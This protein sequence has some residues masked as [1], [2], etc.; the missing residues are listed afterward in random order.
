MDEALLERLERST[1][2]STSALTHSRLKHFAAMAHTSE[3][4]ISRVGLG[5]SIAHGPIADGFNGP[6]QQPHEPPVSVLNAKQIR[7]N[8][9]LKQDGVLFLV[10]MAALDSPSSYDEWR[11]LIVAHWERGVELLTAHAG[12][13]SDWLH[14]MVDLVASP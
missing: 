1:Y 12:A 11:A 3:D 4:H 6:A 10:M 13:R 8:T 9:L 5:L 2:V 14:V 7:G